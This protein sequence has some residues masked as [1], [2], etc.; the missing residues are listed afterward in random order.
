MQK[1]RGCWC[2]PS[3]MFQRRQCSIQKGGTLICSPS[4]SEQKTIS[5][6]RAAQRFHAS[7]RP[8]NKANADTKHPRRSPMAN[9][10]ELEISNQTLACSW[11]IAKSQNVLGTRTRIQR[12]KTE[13]LPPSAHP[14]ETVN[15]CYGS[16]FTYNSRLKRQR[17]GRQTYL[18]DLF[19]MF[20]PP[21]QP[22]SIVDIDHSSQTWAP[23]TAMWIKFE[24]PATASTVPEA[25]KRETQVLRSSRLN[26]NQKA[27]GG[28]HILHSSTSAYCWK[29]DI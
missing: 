5:V 6:V 14:D 15:W 20:L 26:K 11:Q 7:P 16:L 3:L 13:K 27:G 2:K 24:T 8:Q 12:L 28:G 17:R 10:Q 22:D 1:D 19:K 25:K 18:I 4:L 9:D 23:R 21:R 29:Q